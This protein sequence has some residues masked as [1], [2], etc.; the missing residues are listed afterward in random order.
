MKSPAII[1]LAFVGLLGFLAVWYHGVIA[2]T[3]VLTLC[4]MALA[5]A[6]WGG[7]M[8]MVNL[9]HK[10]GEL[11]SRVRIALAKAELP[12]GDPEADTVVFRSDIQSMRD[13]AETLANPSFELIARI[14]DEPKKEDEK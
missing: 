12:V 11:P 14:N 9:M 8:V 5:C 10:N 1:L 7:L 13:D 6:I 4:A 3:I 2:V